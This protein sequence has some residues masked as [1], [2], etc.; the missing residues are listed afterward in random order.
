MDKPNFTTYITS[1]TGGMSG[2]VRIFIELMRRW[3]NRLGNIHII[4]AKIG[5]DVF[6]DNSLEAENIRYTVFS[7]NESEST[8]TFIAYAK[9]VFQGIFHALF[10]K[11][12]S[13]TY[14]YAASDFWPEAIPSIIAKIKNPKIKLIAAFYLFAPAPWDKNSPYRSSFLRY[15][16][17]VL[18]Y[19]MQ[20]P[21]Y[22]LYNILADYVFVT[23]LP[24]VGRF[25]N[26]RRNRNKVL[27]I[28][29][30]VDI[31]EAEKY[32]KEGIS[33]PVKERKYSACFLGRFHYQKGVLHLMDIWK[34]VVGQSPD[35]KLAMIGEGPLEEDIRR[36]IKQ[37]GLEEN[38]DILGFMDGEK[39]Y[40][41]FKD[42]VLMLH[43]AT[44]DS[45]GMAAAEGMAWRLP[46][47]SYD[48][49]A[50]K[51]Y[52]PKG[53]LKVPLTGI[54]ERDVVS[55]AEETL[56][57]LNDDTLYD[58]LAQDALNL[59]REFWDWDRRA[60]IVYNATFKPE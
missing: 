32:H 48:L 10:H 1:V 56:R 58:R 23:S 60:E 11:I 2:G 20:I 50:L 13:H 3:T 9:R 7:P 14:L 38:I 46:G 41:I 57:L 47:V 45:G 39:K 37:Y 33:I 49:E 5:R 27:I 16:K 34:R 30:G 55:F 25:V 36:K 19:L 17:G 24:D 40:G 31:S 22:P 35:A 44:Y 12:E 4:T 43:P 51:T 15:L 52:Y 29:G 26:K 6:R 21:V 18:Y 42:S 28:S 8:P 54:Y 59:C 53:M